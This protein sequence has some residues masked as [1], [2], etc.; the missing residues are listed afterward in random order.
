MT[1]ILPRQHNYMKF[2]THLMYCINHP[3]YLDQMFKIPLNV[4]KCISMLNAETPDPS[5]NTITCFDL[6]LL[7]LSYLSTSL[8]FSVLQAQ[9]LPSIFTLSLP[10]LWHFL[11]LYIGL[12]FIPATDCKFYF[13]FFPF[14][15]NLCLSSN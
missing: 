4:Y 15:Q 2:K 7:Q 11:N 14:L 1:K 5:Q 9:Q 8:Y 6:F 10:K 3:Q 12:K 13:I